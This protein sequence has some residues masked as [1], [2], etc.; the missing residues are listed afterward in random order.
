M[1]HFKFLTFLLAFSVL[2]PAFAQKVE[3]SDDPQTVEVQSG[4]GYYESQPTGKKAAQKFF[5]KGTKESSTEISSR[6]SD[7]FMMIGVGA[8]V[9]SKSYKWGP[10]RAD[11]D[12]GEFNASVTY[13]YGE[14][15]NSMDALFRVEYQSFDV[16]ADT[17]PKKL[18]L[19]SMI[20][21]PDARSG[22]P[23]YFGAGIGVGV[24]MSQPDDESNL[25][26]DYQLVLGGRMLNV[27]ESLG[28]FV[29][30]GIK[31]HVHL[32]SSGQF[33]GVFVTFGSA[34]TF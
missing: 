16:E 8:F 26:F 27:F 24:F 11:D 32:L 18:S 14:W 2:S 19:L 15:V 12:P 20:M 17:D 23:L 25:S 5:S 28:F 6:D 30:T 4:S 1:T 13:R 22:F 21:F 29:E 34:F 3:L 10:K 9:N 33:D 7:H 31:N